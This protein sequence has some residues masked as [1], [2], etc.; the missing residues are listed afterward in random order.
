MPF[1]DLRFAQEQSTAEPH[2]RLKPARRR[3]PR[4][5]NGRIRRSIWLLFLATSTACGGEATSPDPESAEDPFSVTVRVSAEASGSGCSVDWSAKASVSTV[6]VDY[7]VWT[8]N[9]NLASADSFR[10]STLVGWVEIGSGT[11]FPVNWVMSAGL[12]SDSSGTNVSC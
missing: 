4:L 3:T 10:D 9:R 11:S 6:Q 1:H 7:V 8:T 2:D 5:A 12:W